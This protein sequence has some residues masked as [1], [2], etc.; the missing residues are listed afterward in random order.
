[1]HLT[2]TFRRHYGH[3]I[4]SYVRALRL[5]WA[6]G[7][8]AASDQPISHVACAA[9]F[10]DQSHFTRECKKRHGVTPGLY[11]SRLHARD[12]SVCREHADAAD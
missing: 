5:E 3:S 1:M 10:S 7:E 12:V 6:L 11:R 8:L 9:G 4:G 2:R